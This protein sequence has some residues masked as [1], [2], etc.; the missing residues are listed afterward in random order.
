MIFIPFVAVPRQRVAG[1]GVAG[2]FALVRVCAAACSVALSQRPE[3]SF[4]CTHSQ[5]D[6]HGHLLY[7]PAPSEARK[8]HAQWR[9]DCVSGC[10]CRCLPWDSKLVMPGQWAL[11]PP[12]GRGFLVLR[13]GRVSSPAAAYVKVA[14][15]R[16]CGRCVRAAGGASAHR[17]V[18]LSGGDLA[19][20]PGGLFYIP[21]GGVC[22]WMPVAVLKGA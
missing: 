3:G 15:R 10:S 6:L 21:G 12:G 14:S 11:R 19:C 20:L 22:Y 17:G 18:S 13:S 7:V 4:R 9:S 8:R 16:S 2:T 5:S 1:P